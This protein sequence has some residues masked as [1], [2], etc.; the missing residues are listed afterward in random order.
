MSL[1]YVETP[2]GRLALEA[3]GDRLVGTWWASPGERASKANP[4]KPAPV[5]R[6]AARQVD[7]YF[8]RKL[9]RF[10]L[11]IE[12]RG[13]EHQKRV[14]SMMREIPFGGIATYGGIAAAISSA[15]RAVGTACGRNPLPVIVPCHRVLGSG[16]TIGGYSGGRG[17][18]TKRDLLALEGVTVA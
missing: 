6:E 5:L 9:K 4:A 16:G 13:T 17:L 10:D 3:E 1:C 15:P 12:M 14:W 18:A 2:I 7:R 8:R 11:P